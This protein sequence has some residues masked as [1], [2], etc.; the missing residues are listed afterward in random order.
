NPDFIILADTVCCHQTAT[1]V[2]SR[3]GWSG[4]TAVKSKHVIMLNDDIA[5][6]WGPRIVNLLRTVLAAIK[7][8]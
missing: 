4:M 1:T 8:S 6:R 2:A 5:S 7:G 3:P